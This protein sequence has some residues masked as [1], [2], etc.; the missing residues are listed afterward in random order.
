MDLECVVETKVEKPWTCVIDGIQSSTHCTLGK[1]NLKLKPVNENKT[2][3]SFKNLKTQK[4]LKLKLRPEIFTKSKK[5]EDL[6]QG[7]DW[8]LKTP[9]NRLFI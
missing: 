4:I 7:A 3:F 5:F 1:C 6:E 8:V 2:L 9:F